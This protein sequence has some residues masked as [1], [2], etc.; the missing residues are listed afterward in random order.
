M[1]QVL[2]MN[3]DGMAFEGVSEYGA[4]LVWPQPVITLAILAEESDETLAPA[5][6]NIPGH[7]CFREDSFDPVSRIRRGRFYQW[8]GSTCPW[9]V[10]PSTNT[11]ISGTHNINGL[12]SVTLRSY[13]A[14]KLS[15]N[16]DS[17]QAMI[18]LGSSTAFSAWSIVAIETITTGEEL[19]TLKARQSLGALPDV[20]WAKVPTAHRHKVQEAIEKLAD[21]YRR[22]GTESVVDRAREAATAILSAYLQGQGDVSAKGQDLGTLI[23]KLTEGAGQDRQRIIACA[24]EMPQRLHS[25]GKHAEKEKH[26]D[27][28]PIREQDAE[29]AVQCVGVMLCDLRWA[30]WK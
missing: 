23:K 2:G 8:N 10:Y 7:L 5:S 18:V 11:I 25:R 30:D 4:H 24:A 9:N 29:L 3:T 12:I 15:T 16:S 14:H 21:D 1:S 17:A 6:E 20:Y 26:D 13:R 19:V 28:R 27:L 22:A